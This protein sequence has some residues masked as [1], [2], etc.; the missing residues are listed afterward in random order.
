[1]KRPVRL[2][3]L[4]LLVPMAVSGCVFD[5]ERRAGE[6][7]VDEFTDATFYD[8][9]ATLEP[10]D[11]G[12][13]IRAREILS[14]PLGTQAWRVIYHSRDMAGN[15]IPVAGIVIVPDGPAPEEGR[16]IVSWAHPTTGSAQKCGPS[17][18]SNPFLLIEGMDELLAAGYAVAATDYQGMSVAGASSYLL[19][20]TEG[21]NVL[22]AA[23]AARNLEGTGVGS[24]LLLWGHSQGGQAA[25]FAAQQVRDYAP[26]FELEAVAVAAP[27]ADLRQ[28][29]T[30]DIVDLSGVTITSY[31]F[32]AFTAAYA[33]RYSQ[34]QMEAILTPE[35][36]AATP[37]MAALCLLSE[38]KA[39]HAI[40]EPL[41]GHYVTS[42]PATTEPW[43]TLLAENSAGSAPIDVPLYVAQGLAD[44][45]VLPKVTTSFVQRLCDSGE[46]VTFQTFSGVTH[47]FV[48]D[49]ATPDVVGF[50][51]GVERGS[52]PGGNC[53]E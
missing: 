39:I 52:H 49:V 18:D 21:N 16:T 28:L 15:D 53:G 47:G 35:G 8:L 43:A 19:G 48:A 20:V 34:A 9:P 6:E 41:V 24:R 30:D 27:A 14:A 1:M 25:L 40:A 29:L 7:I 3:A 23:R 2:L 37:K 22:D 31:A 11:P 50:F 4:A 17:L 42:D 51:V 32:P 10:G 38:N 26:E 33:D 44:T 46:D 36:L 12:D 5:A 13:I 45:L